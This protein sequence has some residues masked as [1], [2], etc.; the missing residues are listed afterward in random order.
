MVGVSWCSFDLLARPLH[1]RFGDSGGSDED[2]PACGITLATFRELLLAMGAM[3]SQAM[4]DPWVHSQRGF[5]FP[6]N[7]PATKN[8]L[9]F[10]LSL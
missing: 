6:I 4:V 2:L 7:M 8:I 3:A 1:R 10:L 9:R 5:L